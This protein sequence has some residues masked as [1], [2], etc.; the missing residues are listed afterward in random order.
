MIHLICITSKR[1]EPTIQAWQIACCTMTVTTYKTTKIHK[2]TSRNKKHISSPKKNM[3]NKQ[4]L[5]NLSTWV[6]EQNVHEE[7]VGMNSEQFL[8]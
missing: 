1:N 2:W 8:D 3:K 5:N 4:K 6:C 7:Q